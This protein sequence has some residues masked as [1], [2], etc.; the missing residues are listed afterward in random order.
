MN[1]GEWEQKSKE[2]EQSYEVAV[3]NTIKVGVEL[4]TFFK[5]TVGID[6]DGPVTPAA[7][8]TMIS[9]IIEMKKNDPLPG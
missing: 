7:V 9:K 2:L 1:F 6:I 5:K 3:S 8:I 4:K